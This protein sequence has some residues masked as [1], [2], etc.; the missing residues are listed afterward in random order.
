MRAVRHC[1]R[2]L[3][4]D[5]DRTCVLTFKIQELRTGKP[6]KQ[7]QAF[8]HH[9]DAS[10]DLNAILSQ[11]AAKNLDFT[12]GRPQQAGEHLDGSGFAGSV[13][14]QKAIKLLLLHREVK[15]I[16]GQQWAEPAAQSSGLQYGFSHDCFPLSLKIENLYQQFTAL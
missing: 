3:W 6:L 7:C 11:V 9:A 1:A 8:R 4:R 16:H 5:R 10:L 2:R 12:A 14:P 15:I 13:R